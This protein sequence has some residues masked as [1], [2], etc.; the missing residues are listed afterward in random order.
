MSSGLFVV[1]QAVDRRAS[2][3]ARDF[4]AWDLVSLPVLLLAVLG[5]V[6]DALAAGTSQELVALTAFTNCIC[7]LVW[8]RRRGHVVEALLIVLRLLFEI[9]EL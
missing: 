8:R 3:Y 5:A 2:S 6:L 4:L 1:G 7:T 9:E